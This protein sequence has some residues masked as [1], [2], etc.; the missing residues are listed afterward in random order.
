[1]INQNLW[2]EYY[3]LHPKRAKF[4]SDSTAFKRSP[5][6]LRQVENDERDNKFRIDM[7]N[8]LR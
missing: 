4:S 8:L 6:N 3:K 1:M 5:R 2:N 7:K